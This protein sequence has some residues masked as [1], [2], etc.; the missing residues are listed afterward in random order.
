MD[1]TQQTT[2]NTGNVLRA[3]LKSRNFKIFLFVLVI[4]LSLFGYEAKKDAG[5]Q[6]SESLAPSPAPT[7]NYVERQQKKLQAIQELPYVGDKF[8]I[9]YFP[10]DDTFFVQIKQNPY[11]ENKQL[12][13]QW[14]KDRG[15]EVENVQVEWTS[16]RGVY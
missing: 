16:T 2:Q 6:T 10:S 11:E 9:E 5:K 13:V 3:F 15:V 1:N 14:L 4:G 7:E 8:T 12:V